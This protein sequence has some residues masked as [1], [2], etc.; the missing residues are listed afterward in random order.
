MSSR[1]IQNTEQNTIDEDEL[2]YFN[3]ISSIWWNNSALSSL[4]NICG[5]FTPYM[6]SIIQETFPDKSLNSLR[7]LEV[8]CGGGFLSEELARAGCD[9]VA[10]DVTENLLEIAK[11]HSKS[12]P[13]LPKITYLLDSIENHCKENYQQYDVVISNFVLEHVT[14]HDYFIKCCSD[15]VKPNGLLFM[16]GLSKTMISRFLLIFLAENILGM[17]PKGMHHYEKCINALDVENIMKSYNFKIKE[18][19]GLITNPFTNSAYFF[20]STILSYIICAARDN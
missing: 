2:K 5:L 15:C 4:R 9:L 1:I 20:P 10:I 3:S 8:G 13:T 14:D 17:I 6:C 7:I 18:T 12:D 16:S 19:R 11:N